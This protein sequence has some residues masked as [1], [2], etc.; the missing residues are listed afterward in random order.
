MS[1]RSIGMFFGFGAGL[2]VGGSVDSPELA[3]T[4]VPAHINAA[5]K[6]V[7]HRCE[8]P[9]Y[10]NSN[11]GNGGEGRT[12]RFNLVL[13][14]DLARKAALTCSPGKALDVLVELTS[15]DGRVFQDR[16]AL[17][18]PDGTPLTINKVGLTVM[19]IV[20]GEEAQKHIDA[21]IGRNIRPQGWN[22]PASPD[23]QMWANELKRRINLQYTGGDA[24]GFARV[25]QPQGQLLPPEQASGYTQPSAPTAAAPNTPVQAVTAAFGQPAAAPV[26]PTVAPQA[27]TVPVAPA[28]AAYGF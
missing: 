7:G 13:W 5:G 28:A 3:I 1:G 15:Y 24:F 11:R 25:I 10:C 17:T 6:K 27:P 20:F 14:G 18:K 26:Q 21:E 22:N 19:R 9:V 2:R 16:V 12:S 8:I 23:Y 4:F